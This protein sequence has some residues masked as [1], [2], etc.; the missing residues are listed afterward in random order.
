MKKDKKEFR[1]K[2]LLNRLRSGKEITLRDFKSVLSENQYQEY[3]LMWSDEKN[4]RVIEKPKEVIKYEQMLRKVKLANT[5][6]ET[7]GIRKNRIFSVVKKL[8]S[9]SDVLIQELIEYWNDYIKGDSKLMLWFDRNVAEESYIE[10]LPHIVT[11]RSMVVKNRGYLTKYS[12][13]ELKIIALENQLK[14]TDE[15]D[16]IEVIKNQLKSKKKIKEIN[17]KV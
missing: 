5:R 9:E 1:V 11:S 3:L 16:D 10:D 14:P 4:K 7:Y 12:K 8:N 17:F 15:S 13:K 6:A 2:E